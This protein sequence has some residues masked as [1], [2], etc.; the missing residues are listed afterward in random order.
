MATASGDLSDREQRLGEITFACLKA[1]E[2]GG[3]L[4][5]QELLARYPEFAAELAEFFTGRDEVDR[6]VAPLREVIKVATV[7]RTA[8]TTAGETTDPSGQTEPRFLAHYELREEIGR[9]GMGVVYEA[10]QLSLGRRVALKVLPF[11]AALD[12]RQLQRF[13]HEAQAAAQLHHANIVPVYAVGCERG[14]HYYAM[15]RI[16]GQNL[17]AVIRELRRQVGRHAEH[18]GPATAAVAEVAERLLSG[19]RLA[20]GPALAGDSRIASAPSPPPAPAPPSA[21]TAALAGLW[22]ERSTWSPAYFRAVADLGV[23]AAEALA[24]AHDE[25]VIHRDIKPAN[26]LVEWRAGVSTSNG[27]RGVLTP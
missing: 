3:P 11:A 24:H 26:L 19:Q 20:A 17:A 15:Q 25:G 13:K 23:Q 8:E 1:M 7:A 18:D 6:L 27:E 2:T 10:V 5:R 4:D 14:V 22:T 21:E 16:D 12:P 9:G